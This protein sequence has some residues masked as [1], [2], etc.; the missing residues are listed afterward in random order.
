MRARR[1]RRQVGACRWVVDHAE[2]VVVPD[3]RQDPFEANAILAEYGLCAYA[4]V[5]L[6]AEKEVLGVLYA[7]DQSPRN[8]SPE[9]LDFLRALAQRAATAI[10]K[11]RLYESLRQAR[12]V[13][14][15]ASR[16][17]SEF[18]VNISHEIR[19]PLNGV[20]GRADLAL[21]TPLTRE[22]KNYLVAIRKSGAALL[23]M[24]NDLLDFS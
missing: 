15:A 16:A 23:E 19:T 10:A 18:L 17:Q 22:Q 3:T 24:I 14:E 5:P 21:E 8:Y 2:A 1:V 11:V 9:D 4:G 12:N 13:A 7:L 20:I 6:L